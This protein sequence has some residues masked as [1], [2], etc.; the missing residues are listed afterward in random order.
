LRFA[1]H[2]AT[3]AGFQQKASSSSRKVS[4][5]DVILTEFG[6]SPGNVVNIF[7]SKLIKLLSVLAVFT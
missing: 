2:S 3:G 1:G 5:G 6:I 4:T 7:N